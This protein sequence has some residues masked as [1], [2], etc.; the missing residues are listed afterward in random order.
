[1]SIKPTNSK[2][3][4]F[5]IRNVLMLSSTLLYTV[6]NIHRIMHRVP[7]PKC[8]LWY[9][10]TVIFNEV[11]IFENKN[12]VLCVCILYKER[13]SDFSRKLLVVLMWKCKNMC[14]TQI[15]KEITGNGQFCLDNESLWGKTDFL[16]HV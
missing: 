4:E 16:G 7:V 3:Y 13:K 8:K 5:Q 12:T 14:S 15:F 9:S 1:M 10:I 2:Y 6:V 11:L